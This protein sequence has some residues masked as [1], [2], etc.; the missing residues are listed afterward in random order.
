MPVESVIEL[1]IEPVSRGVAR[2]ARMRQVQ[3]H[4]TRV[5][6]AREVRGVAGVAVLRHCRV[7]AVCVALGAGYGGVRAGEREY[8]RVVE[9]RRHPSARRVAESAIGGEAARDVVRVRRSGEVPFMARVAVRRRRSVVVIRVA[10]GAR[11][12]GMLAGQRIV[13]EKGVIEFCIRPVDC[14]VAS[15]AIV[16]EAKLNMGRVLAVCEIRGVAGIA[17]GRCSGKHII[18]MA[19]GALQRRMST[20]QRVTCVFQMVKLGAD[21]VV[22]GV[23]GLAVGGEIERHMVD[24][25]R[26][27]VLLMA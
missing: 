25:R 1:G 19:G 20:G 9:I 24:D 27:E 22:H 3:L 26:E 17:L 5:V 2:V 13:R 11:H 7:V 4:V 6:G 14:G 21:K 18:D 23:A 15:A 16:G 10:L 12:G 8:R